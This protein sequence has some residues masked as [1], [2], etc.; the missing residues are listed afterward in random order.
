MSSRPD[1]WRVFSIISQIAAGFDMSAGEKVTRTQP[2]LSPAIQQ[3]E[4]ELGGPLFHR[5][6]HLTHEAHEHCFKLAQPK[7]CWRGF[8]AQ[9]AILSRLCPLL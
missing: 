4:G 5:E 8:Q 9:V 7:G 6:R 2:S 3:L 1:V